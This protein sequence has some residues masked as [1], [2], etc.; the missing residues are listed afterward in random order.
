M[1]SCKGRQ[2]RAT[3]LWNQI[4][5]SFRDGLSTGKHRKHMRTYDNCFIACDAVSWLH[6]YLRNDKNFGPSVTRE[7]TVQLLQKFAESYIIKAVKGSKRKPF[8]DDKQ[9]YR[10]VA[11]SSPKSVKSPARPKARTPLQPRENHAACLDA[12]EPLPAPNFDDCAEKE[13]FSAAGQQLQEIRAKDKGMNRPPLPMA[14][15]DD[16]VHLIWRSVTLARL[17]SLLGKCNVDDIIGG[18]GVSGRVIMHNMCQLSR[19]GVVILKEKNDDLP[20]WVINAMKC[21]IHWPKTTGGGSSLPNYPGFEAD[22]L[23]VV[24]EFFETFGMH[25]VPHPVNKLFCSAFG[26][27]P[28]DESDNED[29]SQLH[30]PGASIENLLCSMSV[31]GSLMHLNEETQT[32]QHPKGLTMSNV[33]GSTSAG[34]PNAT[35]FGRLAG[36]R[37]SLTS[38]SSTD[39]EAGSSTDSASTISTCSSALGRPCVAGV[40]RMRYADAELGF[41]RA[42]YQKPLCRATSFEDLSH[43]ACASA[44][45]PREAVIKSTASL[46]T[47]GFLTLRKIKRREEMRKVRN[48][49]N[50]RIECAGGYVNPAFGSTWSVD[51]EPKRLSSSVDSLA[52]SSSLAS[53]LSS[54][55]GSCKAV[56]CVSYRQS[57]E[58]FL[59]GRAADGKSK[60]MRVPGVKLERSGVPFY[61]HETH[62]NA[63]DQ[64]DS[65]I[66]QIAASALQ[67]S[68][69]LLPPRSRRY[70]HLLLRFI[71]KT[72][73]NSQLVLSS[74][75]SNFDVLVDCFMDTFFSTCRSFSVVQTDARRLLTFLVNHC[76]AVF[77]PPRELHLEVEA[78]LAIL[79]RG[80]Q[81]CDPDD[82]PAIAY[83]NRVSTVEFEA[84]KKYVSEKALMDLFDDILQDPRL[85]DKERSRRMKQFQDNYPDIYNAKTCDHQATGFK[86]STRARS[87]VIGLFR[88]LRL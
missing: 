3:W 77:V 18:Y 10:F 65:D 32:V 57:A 54:S 33:C 61:A 51:S 41:H 56:E 6:D 5:K 58:S 50:L 53:S 45:A 22:V 2:Y 40:N 20:K 17:R 60:I 25:L 19:N 73:R 28:D 27:L 35:N 34:R 75:R 84:Q 26:I 39:F 7:Q 64:N 67:V 82:P 15:R 12:A 11:R 42:E 88:S 68:S 78:R 87:T 44:S 36:D 29:N 24:G 9:L 43:Y 23:K 80:R 66:L 76:D 31:Q 81:V 63:Y 16:E 37:A 72:S 1:E 74:T 70:L 86:R 48:D 38:Y 49:E 46:E 21:L 83:C 30:S 71:Y 8:Q 52:C 85:S 79:R 59:S 14:L 55:T 62:L 69:L 47:K 13:H 4:I